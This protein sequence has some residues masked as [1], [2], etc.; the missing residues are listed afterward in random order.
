MWEAPGEGAAQGQE[1]VLTSAKTSN[2]LERLPNITA[3]RFWLWSP[4]AFQTFLQKDTESLPH[5]LPSSS[6]LKTL[7]PFPANQCPVCRAGA[8]SLSPPAPQLLNAVRRYS[9]PSRT[10]LSPLAG[11]CRLLR[12]Q[13]QDVP[14][15]GLHLLSLSLCITSTGWVEMSHQGGQLPRQSPINTDT[16]GWGKAA[17]TNTSNQKVFV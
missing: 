7:P 4:E 9:R 15:N 10:A 6:P 3:L 1:G 17:K 14:G 5:Q 16:R 13:G 11:L 2:R 8:P 12:A